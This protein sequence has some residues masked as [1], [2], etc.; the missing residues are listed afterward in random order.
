MKKLFAVIGAFLLACSLPLSGAAAGKQVFSDVPPSKHFAE[1]VNE[2]AARNII[3]GYP[4]GTFKPGNSIT[5]GQ[6]AAIIA[7]M[8]GL[9]TSNVKGQKFKDVP[10]SHGFYKAIVK[11]AEEGIIGGYPDGSFKPNEPIKRKNMAAILVKAFD[12]PRSADVKNPFKG[13][14]G[15]TN[16]VLVI[17]KLGITSGT[18]PTT[19][20]PN[21]SITR[22]QAAKMLA[23]TEQVMMKS[24]V[25]V[26]AGDL[27]WDTIESVI[28]GEINP[29]VFRAVE[30]KGKKDGTQD[31]VQLFP[32]KEGK[33]GIAIAGRKADN[34][35]EI[36]KYYVH[37]KKEGSEL[38]LTLEKTDES[39]PTMASLNTKYKTVQNIALAKVDG[40]NI[41]DNVK[42][43][44]TEYN[45]TYIMIEKPGEYIATIRFANGEEVRYSLSAFEMDDSFFYGTSA[46]ELGPADFFE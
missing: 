14:V 27:G 11:M 4:D 35:W 41:S 18:S 20:S 19:F 43:E 10:A 36:Q 46:I 1:A 12:L 5:R 32:I 34:E 2:L 13:E 31:E 38:R 26:K 33:S 40:E 22:G 24:A 21:A 28:A 45:F 23:A 42:I 44:K 8:I 3:G 39:L 15:I 6:A 29:G 7:K 9:D 17:Y 16:D 30:V 37:V 25:T